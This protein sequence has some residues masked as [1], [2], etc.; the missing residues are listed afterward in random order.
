MQWRWFWTQHS[1]PLQDCPSFPREKKKKDMWVYAK[2]L[3]SNYQDEY[4]PILSSILDRC[5]LWPKMIVLDHVTVVPVCHCVKAFGLLPPWWSKL[6]NKAV[7][8]SLTWLY[9]PG[10]GPQVGQVH[11]GFPAIYYGVGVLAGSVSRGP[12]CHGHLKETQHIFHWPHGYFLQFG[13]SDQVM[14]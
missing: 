12:V 2:L 7:V 3:S 11:I 13:H 4:L 6:R 9:D 5:L 14:D 10:L 1:D 8:Q